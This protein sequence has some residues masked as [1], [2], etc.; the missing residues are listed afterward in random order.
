MGALTVLCSI[1]TTHPWN[2][3]GVG[4]DARVAQRMDARHVSVI[5]GITAQGSGESAAAATPAELLAAQLR[6]VRDLRPD[7]YRIGALIS[8]ANV[9][10]VA[11][12]LE[13]STVPVVCDPVIAT[14]GGLVLAEPGAV[15]AQRGKLFRHCTLVTPNLDEASRLCDFPVSDRATMAGAAHTLVQRDAAHAAL[16]TGGH[17]PDEAS[18]VLYADGE[19]TI[20]EGT[21][22]SGGMR[23]TGCALAEAAAI[24]LAR[25]LNVR[26]AIAVARAIVRD[27][28]EHAIEWRGERVW[29]W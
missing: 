3:A 1:G 11:D 28:I 25:G 12:F 19:S 23:G 17:L 15:D 27:A 22:L 4:L 13:R 8:A 16:V 7:A 14:S 9:D 29:P 26:D 5:A 10:V 2:I 21:R 6:A 20:F 24:S 18:D